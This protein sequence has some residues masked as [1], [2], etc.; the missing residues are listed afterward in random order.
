VAFKSINPHNPSE[1]I[2]EFEEAGPCDVEIAIVRARE[3]FFEWREQPASVRGGALANM[4]KDVEKWAD[5]L[6]RLTVTEVGE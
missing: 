2:G 3:A 1:V 6:I 4:A 5:E